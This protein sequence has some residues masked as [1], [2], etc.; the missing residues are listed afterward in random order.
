MAHEEAHV[1]GDW[2]HALKGMR[3]IQDLTV[4]TGNISSA[5]VC[6]RI[7]MTKSLVITGKNQI[8]TR[9]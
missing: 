5:R 6:F 3:S 4:V 2:R 9:D 8:K 7:G 1:E